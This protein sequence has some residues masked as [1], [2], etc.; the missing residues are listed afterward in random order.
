[1]ASIPIASAGGRVSSRVLTRDECG[2]PP[3]ATLGHEMP[4][5]LLYGVHDRRASRSGRCRLRKESCAPRSEPVAV[6][7]CSRERLY[8]HGSTEGVPT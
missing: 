3:P 5:V 8:R 6:R 1:M 4:R 7:A 2:M